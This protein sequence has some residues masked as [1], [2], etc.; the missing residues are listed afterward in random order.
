VRMTRGDARIASVWIRPR[1]QRQTPPP[2]V[3]APDPAAP[4]PVRP[5]SDGISGPL[6]ELAF[7]TLGKL[8]CDA[9]H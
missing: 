6:A 3:T 2:R 4:P 5:S 9:F 7:R 1:A 8:I